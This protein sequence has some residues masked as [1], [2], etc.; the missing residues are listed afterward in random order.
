MGWFIRDVTAGEGLEPM[1][2]G[3]ETSCRQHSASACRLDSLLFVS[4]HSRRA[5]LA[6]EL[7]TKGSVRP[8]GILQ[9]AS[10]REQHR[11][12][13]GWCS[14]ADNISQIGVATPFGIRSWHTGPCHT[15]W[16]HN[17]LCGTMPLHTGLCAM[18]VCAQGAP[19]NTHSEQ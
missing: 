1:T 14:V 7:G 8:Q 17:M 2:G 12:V 15:M 5:S 13:T 18:W 10:S 3:T 9:R 6:F 4:F 16:D 11:A 19:T